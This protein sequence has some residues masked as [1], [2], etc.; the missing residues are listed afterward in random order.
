MSQN[1]DTLEYDYRVLQLIE[2]R[3]DISQR[4]LASQLGF[5]VGK[6]NYVLSALIERGLVKAEN[7][8]RSN[9]KAGYLYLLTPKGISDKGVITARFLKRK[10]EEYER[11][12]AEIADIQSRIEE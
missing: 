6:T 1:S 3:P 9:N 5:S 2:E 4:E 10:V 12:K 8:K 11:L 7:F